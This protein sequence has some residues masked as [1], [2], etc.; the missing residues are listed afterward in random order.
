MVSFMIHAN[1][2][3]V[4]ETDG[5]TG[6]AHYLEHLAFKGTSR[7]GTKDFAAEQQVM[8]QL[9]AVFSDLLAAQTAGDTAKA[10]DREENREK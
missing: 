7:I 4:D 9:D 2:G 5:K 1:V 6:V 8:A 10:A 3:A